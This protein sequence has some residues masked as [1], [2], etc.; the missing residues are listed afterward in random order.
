[1]KAEP[2]DYIETDHGTFMVLAIDEDCYM[3][4][5]GSYVSDSDITYEQVRLSSEV[6]VG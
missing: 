3:M 1:M 5:D 2:G 4:E 6:E